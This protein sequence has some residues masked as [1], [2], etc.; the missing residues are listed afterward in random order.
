MCSRSTGPRPFRS[1]GDPRSLTNG[2]FHWV[3]RGSRGKLAATMPGM[4]ECLLC[5]THL[6]IIRDAM[7][8]SVQRCAYRHRGPVRSRRSRAVRSRHCHLAPAPCQQ[9]GDWFRERSLA[10]STGHLHG[11]SRDPVCPTHVRMPTYASHAERV[12]ERFHVNQPSNCAVMIAIDC[13]QSLPQHLSC[14]REQHRCSTARRTT[15]SGPPA[16]PGARCLLLGPEFTAAPAS[17][18]AIRARCPPSPA[19]PLIPG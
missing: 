6:L 14:T 17:G 2:A 9:D 7:R 16:T 5:L 10:E 15:R 12:P 13:G 3:F 18:H 19:S 1:C 11:S 4:V 8:V